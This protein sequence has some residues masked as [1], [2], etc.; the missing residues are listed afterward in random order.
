MEAPGRGVVSVADGPTGSRDVA[1]RIKRQPSGQAKGSWSF[2]PSGS[3][4]AFLVRGRLHDVVTAVLVYA[5]VSICPNPAASWCQWGS[6]E[7]AEPEP[8]IKQLL[9]W[10]RSAGGHRAH[11]SRLHRVPL[12]AGAIRRGPPLAADIRIAIDVGAEGVEDAE[13]VVEEWLGSVGKGV[14]GYVTPKMR[15]ERRSATRRARSS[16]C[17]APTR[18]CGST[19]RRRRSATRPPMLVKEVEEETGIEAEVVRLV[20]VLDGLRIGISRI[21]LYSLVFQC[22]PIGGELRPHPLEC[23][24]VGWFA[25]E[26]LP[27]PLAGADGGASTSSRRCAASTSTSSTTRCARRSGA[28]EPERS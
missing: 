27:Y 8:S 28:G 23:S 9:R 4:R 19:R 7:Q 18:A 15:S 16:S 25:P 20:A 6:V 11:G 26:D 17:G 22:R 12:R 2:G 13:G 1:R 21:P 14:P 24:D 5:H 10:E 3:A